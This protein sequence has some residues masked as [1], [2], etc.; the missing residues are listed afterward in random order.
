MVGAGQLGAEGLLIVMVI[1]VPFNFHQAVT[2]SY[3]KLTGLGNS[4]FLTGLDD[5]SVYNDFYGMLE[6]LFQLDFILSYYLYLAVHPYTGKTFFLYS[7][8]NLFVGSFSLTDHRGH[9]HQLGT[10]LKSHN[11]IYH[12]INRLAGNRSAAD[13]AVGFAYPGIEQPQIIVDFRYGSHSRSGI[14]VCG[15]LVYGNCRRKPL[16]IL[17]IRLFHLTKELAGI[18]RKALHVPPLSLCIYGIEGQ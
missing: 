13:R 17:H 18:G 14:S 5:D 12:L 1:K 2:L 11:G 15:F 8:N 7:L 6:G 3:G 9:Y 16:N 4:P 10:L